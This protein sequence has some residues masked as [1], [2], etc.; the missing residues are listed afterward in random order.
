MLSTL[1]QAEIENDECILLDIKI[2]IEDGP[3]LFA[4]P[5]SFKC[6]ST[7]CSS[8]L[9]SSMPKYQGNPLNDVLGQLVAVAGLE[10]LKDLID[11]GV[12]PLDRPL[13]VE[14]H[15]AL[16]YAIKSIDKVN[17]LIKQFDENKRAEE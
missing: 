2:P 1:K 12:I 3:N 14:G 6:Q 9:L 16:Y 7:N 17:M 4:L 5:Y 15:G 11:N 10:E 8:F 13:S